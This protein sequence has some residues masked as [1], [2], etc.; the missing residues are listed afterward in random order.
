MN[1][2]RVLLC[3]PPEIRYEGRSY[4]I[5]R[6]TPRALLYYLASQGGLVSRDQLLTLFWE[7]TDNLS[8]RRKLTDTLTRLR[9][10][11]PDP[12]ALQADLDLVGLDPQRVYV[13]VLDFQELVSQA[14]RVPWQVPDNDPLP[15]QIHEIL[16]KAAELWRT[17]RFLS[18]ANLPSTPGLDGWLTQTSNHL[19]NLLLRVLDRLANHALATGRLE[20]SL[21]YT[22]R[23][24][25][26]D[27][28]NEDANYR[29]MRLLVELGYI[30]QARDLYHQVQERYRNE[31]DTNPPS[32]LVDVY[33]KIRAETKPKPKKTPAVTWK[34]RPTLN[35]PFVGR[36]NTLEQLQRAY[37]RGGGVFI[38]G[39]PGLGKS[40]LLQEFTDRLSPQ[41]RLVVAT[42]R[43]AESSLP[44]QPLIDLMRNQFLPDEWL[45]L[46]AA[47]ASQLALLMPDISE[48]RP[49]IQRPSPETMVREPPGQAR[50]LIM[51]AIRQVMALL[52]TRQRLVFCLDDAHWSDEATLATIAFLLERPPFNEKGFL[53]VAARTGEPNPHLEQIVALLQ[54]SMRLPILPLARLNA[55]EISEL[56]NHVTGQRPTPPVTQQLLLETGGNPFFLLESLR[57]RMETAR[58]LD[59]SEKVTLPAGESIQDLIKTRLDR[60][61]NDVI[62][63]L[64][65]AAILGTDFDPTI[66]LGMAEQTAGQIAAGLEELEKRAFI[67]AIERSPKHPKY[68]FSHELIRETLLQIMNPLRA[69]QMHLMAAQTLERSLPVE[70]QAAVLAHHFEMGGQ[71]DLAFKYWALA[72]T[73]A[74]QLAS[75]T[76]AGQIFSRAESLISRSPQLADEHIF[77][78]YKDWT[79]ITYGI[80]DVVTL[81]RI[82]SDLLAYGRQRSSPLLIGAALD[83]LSEACLIS[84][85]IEDGLSYTDQALAYLEKAGNLYLRMQAYNHRGVFLYMLNRI[86]EAKQSFQDAL[87]LAVDSLDSRAIHA[88]ANAHFQLAVVRTINGWPEAALTHASRSLAD[89]REIQHVHAQIAALSARAMANYFLGN[90]TTALEDSRTGIA[91]AQRAQTWRMLGYH[92]IYRAMIELALGNVQTADWHANQAIFLG[93]EYHHPE[94][95]ASGY[96]ILGDTFFYLNDFKASA[97]Q[98]NLAVE[99]SEDKFLA[100]DADFRL[101]GIRVFTEGSAEAEQMLAEI[102]QQCEQNGMGLFWI[103]ANLSLVHAKLRRAEWETASQFSALM[104]E[105]A[106]HR[107]LAPVEWM[108]VVFHAEADLET[109]NLQEAA[110]LCQQVVEAS[111][112]L[113]HVWIELKARALL[114]RAFNQM[115]LEDSANLSK[116]RHL[117]NDIVNRARS[118]PYEQALAQFQNEYSSMLGIRDPAKTNLL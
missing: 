118:G 65:C 6:K 21:D 4:S 1:S 113:P 13:D 33:R 11:L 72:M 22:R 14:G 75:V 19:E 98:Y 82:N 81:Q 112:R 80:E 43:P 73:H 96:R 3:G 7:E 54:Q 24:L 39:E 29:T 15:D 38:F 35:A 40:R 78:L 46:P 111:T 23:I 20:H 89:A 68:R 70:E 77:E 101:L 87:A 71:F 17:P 36:R 5:P 100:V 94:I 104:Q 107:K 66:L 59:F 57:V 44:F 105:E 41:P 86:E 51:E 53:V 83:G 18:G 116:A 10:S 27:E 8:A 109:G 62:S 9:A 12:D 52:S 106:E 48:M 79:E 32:R 67:E 26:I 115:G 93:A 56:T 47:W 99:A 25:T 45:A 31:L 16:R 97:E 95:K 92:H 50:A 49:D 64:E 90:F 102:I 84:N 76:E 74:R 37:L 63:L 28:L 42:C 34:I 114:H 58:P 60:L 55:Y 85:L 30:Q 108:S 110:R 61:E 91:L 88:R 69:R 2:L 103:L 117:L